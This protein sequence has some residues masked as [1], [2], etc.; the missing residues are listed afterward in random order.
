MK[1]KHIVQAIKS[2]ERLL[3]SKPIT[4][5]SRKHATE[6]KRTLEKQLKAKDA[7]K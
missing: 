5:Q 4:A 1:R 6:L 7:K 3:E 2:L